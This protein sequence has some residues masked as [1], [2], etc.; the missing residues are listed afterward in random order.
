MILE[1]ITEKTKFN[2]IYLIHNR[3]SCTM[4]VMYHT[5]LMRD[6]AHQQNSLISTPLHSLN[7]GKQ[8][9][10]LFLKILLFSKQLLLLCLWQESQLLQCRN[11]RQFLHFVK[12]SYIFQLLH[13]ISYIFVLPFTVTFLFFSYWLLLNKH[14]RILPIF[15]KIVAYLCQ[16]IWS[17]KEGMFQENHNLS[18]CY[19][20]MRVKNILQSEVWHHSKETSSSLVLD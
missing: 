2:K 9:S 13:F 6:K 7:A 14:F 3:W 12:I 16:R 5:V 4:N 11:C 19:V 10:S 18:C 17:Y 8:K 1:K 15:G 20:N